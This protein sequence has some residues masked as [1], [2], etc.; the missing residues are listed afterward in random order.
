MDG[1]HIISRICDRFFDGMPKCGGALLLS[2]EETRGFAGLTRCCFQGEDII[3]RWNIGAAGLLRS[4]TSDATPALNSILRRLR[5]MLLAAAGDDGD[6]ALDA[7]LRSFFNGPLKTIEFED[8]EEQGD[9]ERGVSLNF[10]DEIEADGV[11]ENS[12]DDAMP[13]A[14]AGDD[15]VFGA[16]LRTQNA[17]EV[18]GLLTGER[19]GVFVPT[20]GNPSTSRHGLVIRILLSQKCEMPQKH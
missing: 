16:G 18:R 19:R 8:G 6:D 4:F 2:Q 17:D 13:D 7:Q 20:V 11:A 5:E 15:I 14:V 1:W 9:G 3:D 10:S 12:G